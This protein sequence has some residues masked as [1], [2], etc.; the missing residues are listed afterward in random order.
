MLPFKRLSAQQ[1]RDLHAI[2]DGHE[3][4]DPY[5]LRWEGFIEGSHED[6][7]QL[8]QEGR[9]AYVYHQEHYIQPKT[10]T[11]EAMGVREKHDS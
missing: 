2:I 10:A 11:F 4:E 3:P 9:K 8:T 5:P 6:G 1:Y 7:W